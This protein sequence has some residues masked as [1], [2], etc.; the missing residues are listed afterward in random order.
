M[1]SLALPLLLAATVSAEELPVLP[2]HGVELSAGAEVAAASR[3][4]WRG[5]P[6][7]EG[8][9]LQPSAWLGYQNITLAAWTNINLGPDDGAGLNEVDIVLGLDQSWED[10]SFSPGIVAYILPGVG[11][12]AE[13][14]GD[15]AWQP[16]PLGLYSNHAIDFWDARPGWW[17]ESGVAFF[18][19][20]PSSLAVSADLGVSLANRPYNTYYLGLDRAGLQYLCGELGLGWVHDSG[21]FVDLVGHLDLLV[22]DE[23]R[24]AL[25][26][27]L[28]L[29]HALVSVGW[30]GGTVWVR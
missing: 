23:I 17:S 16:G 6:I 4:V 5:M 12:T 8:P 7:G 2:G 29:W 25:G 26:T 10:L 15:V 30:E 1:P 14:Y 21:L 3:Y 27:D 11:F 13:A 20:L 24:T 18:T 28:V 22:D 9:V 19:V